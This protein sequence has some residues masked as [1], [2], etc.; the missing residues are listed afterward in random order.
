MKAIVY[1]RFGGP[2]VLELAELPPPKMQQDSVLIRVRAAGLNPADNLIRAGAL[3]EAM[4]TLFP[5]VPGWDVAGVVEQVGPGVTEFAEGDE[6]IGYLRESVLHHGSYA[7]FVS[8]PVHTL[9]RKPSN[10]SWAQAAGLP[11]AGLTAYQGMVHHL[12]VAPG[13]T[14]LVHAAGGG[15]GSIAAQ[16]AVATG[17]TVIGT[18]SAGNH[19]Y[20]RSLGVSPIAYG[21]GLVERVRGCAPEGVDAVFD[22]A[23]RGVLAATAEVGKPHARA[24]TIADVHPDATAVYARLDLDDLRALTR[25]VEAGDLTIRIGATFPLERAAD[26]QRTLESGHAAGKI[27]LTP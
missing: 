6:V 7:E 13:E 5:V 23:G 3:A 15:V 27:I 10:A 2:D 8:A 19:D 22:A 26:A 20:L 21:P 17:A 1:R 25:M 16:I 11:L 14:V 9:V 12:R 4:D 18:A 24:V